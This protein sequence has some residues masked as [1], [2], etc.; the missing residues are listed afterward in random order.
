ME[1]QNSIAHNLSGVEDHLV[2]LCDRGYKSGKNYIEFTLLTEPCQSSTIIGVTHLRS[3]YYF[4]M[5]DHK[6]FW[7]YVPSEGTKIGNN[8]TTE[9][10]MPCKI[11]DKV[12]LL[13][14]FSKTGLDLILF[15]NNV[16]VCTLFKNLPN[17]HLYYPCSVLKFDGMKIKVSNRVPIPSLEH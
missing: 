5:N 8:K 10:G 13:L 17:S 12:G 7:G 6:N 15:I 1:N 16:E 9:V 11:N 14:S 2:V 4:N 3:D